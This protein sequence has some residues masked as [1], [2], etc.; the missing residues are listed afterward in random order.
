MSL[1]SRTIPTFKIP[2]RET[3]TGASKVTGPETLVK[4]KGEHYAVTIKV[5]TGINREGEKT[6]CNS[7]R[8]AFNGCWPC[9]MSRALEQIEELRMAGQGWISTWF[10]NEGEN[11]ESDARDVMRD[12][13]TLSKLEDK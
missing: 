8:G 3:M 13:L 5:R 12:A 2:K 10:N 11:A 6:V 1:T 4:L 7:C 9:P